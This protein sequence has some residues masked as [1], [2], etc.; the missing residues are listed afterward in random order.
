MAKLRVPKFFLAH[1]NLLRKMSLGSKS[2]EEKEELMEGNWRKKFV[3]TTS[4][5]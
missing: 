2:I 1:A 4:S 5:R 3:M